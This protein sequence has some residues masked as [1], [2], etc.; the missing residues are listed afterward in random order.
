M[1][2]FKRL[3]EGKMEILPGRILEYPGPYE[4]PDN[5]RM[6]GFFAQ[7]L[8]KKFKLFPLRGIPI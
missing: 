3:L 5:P 2:P 4:Y 6:L 1:V 8:N 7:R